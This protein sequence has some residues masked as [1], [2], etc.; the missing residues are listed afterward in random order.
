MAC[1]TVFS[2]GLICPPAKEKM[3]P[4]YYQ[5]FAAAKIPLIAL[6]EGGYIKIIAGKCKK[7]SGWF[8]LNIA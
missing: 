1:Y 5:E 8:V 3:K 7:I 6:E 2:Y 4:T